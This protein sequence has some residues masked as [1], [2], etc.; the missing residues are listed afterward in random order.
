MDTTLYI[1]LPKTV[2]LPGE[3]LKGEVLWALEKAPEKL[4]LSLGWWTEGRGSKDAKITE[5]LEWQAPDSAGKQSFE[6]TLPE[7]PYSLEGHL[8]SIKWG[9]ELSTE[10]GKNS[11]ALDIVISPNET[12]IELPLIENESKR[13]SFP[14]GSRR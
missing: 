14:F 10:K 2:Y 11:Q 6:I 8:I 4:Y 7:T 13:K 5:E 12:A 9:L 3:L 1:D